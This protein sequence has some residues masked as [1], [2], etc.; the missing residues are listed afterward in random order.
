M[1]GGV[2]TVVGCVVLMPG[3]LELHFSLH[4]SPLDPV[5]KAVC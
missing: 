3:E 2:V 1:T 4:F 5:F